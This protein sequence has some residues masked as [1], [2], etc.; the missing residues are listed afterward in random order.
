MNV[1]FEEIVKL[2][3]I[4]L[5]LLLKVL[6]NIFLS[7]DKFS[8]VQIELTNIDN[9][10][11]DGSCQYFDPSQLTDTINSITKQRV[12]VTTTSGSNLCELSP[13]SPSPCQ[14]GST[15]ALKDV[16]GGYECT[17]QSGYT[18]VNCTLDVDE[19]N[20]SELLVISNPV[21]LDILHVVTHRSLW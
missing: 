9:P 19:C 8:V 7:L 5:K 10:S 6:I 15:C 11:S 3:L 17:C 21:T 20:Q 2:I 14:N 18:G 4:T 16:V 13:C 1:L 12:V